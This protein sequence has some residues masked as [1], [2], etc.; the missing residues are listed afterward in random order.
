MFGEYWA[1][2]SAAPPDYTR[3]R[4]P[5][6]A[7][8]SVE[9]Q[10]FWLADDAS[11]E[12]RAK[13]RAFERGPMAAWVSHSSAQ[14]RAGPADRQVVELNAGH[15]LFLHRPAETLAVIERF[16]ERHRRQ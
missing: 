5:A 6:L 11:P 8:Y 1:S 14:F 2:A 13:M 10:Q 4:A 12:L 9:D 15:H 7:I 16:L 3:I